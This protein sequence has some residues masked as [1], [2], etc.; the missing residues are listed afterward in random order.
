M[1]LTKK[2]KNIWNNNHNMY[3]NN[4]IANMHKT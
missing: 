3:N 2:E 4:G 1:K